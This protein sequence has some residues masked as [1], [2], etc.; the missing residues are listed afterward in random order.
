MSGEVGTGDE[1]DGGAEADEDGVAA[2]RG[3]CSAAGAG[4]AWLAL[5]LVGLARRRRRP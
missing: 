3:G 5:A 1:D 2:D 4:S